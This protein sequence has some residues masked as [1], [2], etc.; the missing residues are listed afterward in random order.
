MIRAFYRLCRNVYTGTEPPQSMEGMDAFEKI[1]R[2]Y[3]FN[4]APD[5][6][7][8]IFPVCTSLVTSGYARQIPA[9]LDALVENLS[10][11][12]M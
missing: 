7:P 10:L 4:R 11:P 3:S 2:G 8:K 6:A 1:A 12:C 5:S 9:S